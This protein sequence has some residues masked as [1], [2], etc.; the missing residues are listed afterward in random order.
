MNGSIVKT[1]PEIGKVSDAE[2][3]EGKEMA[4]DQLLNYE[5][6]AWVIFF[7][8]CFS[9]G[10]Q[11]G[12][13]ETLSKFSAKPCGYFSAVCTKARFCYKNK[14]LLSWCRPDAGPVRN[15]LSCFVLE[16]KSQP[17]AIIPGAF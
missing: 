4:G 8:Q 12:K 9:F 16:R 15:Y 14:L 7:I 17:V 13:A 10:Q 5:C 11:S 1:A 3:I 2:Q 6:A